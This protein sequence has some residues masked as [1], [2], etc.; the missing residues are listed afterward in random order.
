MLQQLLDVGT[1]ELEKLHFM[2]SSTLSLTTPNLL[3]SNNARRR[4]VRVTFEM[5]PA[6][7][8]P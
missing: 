4:S 5:S 8:L 1:V 2:P 3:I 6:F 7:Y